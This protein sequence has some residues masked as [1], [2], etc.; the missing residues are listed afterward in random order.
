[1]IYSN[2]ND[3]VHAVDPSPFGDFVQ[4]LRFKDKGYQPEAQYIYR[5]DQ[6][7]LIAGGSYFFVDR[8]QNIDFGP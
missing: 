4:D 3:K 2:T 5:A 6:F 8:D 1:M 7:N